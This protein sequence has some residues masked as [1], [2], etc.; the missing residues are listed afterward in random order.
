MEHSRTGENRDFAILV[1]ASLKLDN[2]LEDLVELVRLRHVQGIPLLPF[3]SGEI[4]H[5]WH[6]GAQ[7]AHHGATITV[8]IRGE[9]LWAWRCTTSAPDLGGV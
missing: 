1:D 4:L 3:C 6:R 9:K 7:P 2:G 8:E 5:P